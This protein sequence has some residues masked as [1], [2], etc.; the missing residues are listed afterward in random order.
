MK[1]VYAAIDLKSFYSSVECRERGLDPLTTNL[2]V[3]DQSRTEKTICLAVSPNLREYGIPGRARLFEVIARVKAINFDR[4]KNAPNGKFIGKSANKKVLMDHPE[5]ALDFIVAKPR[6]Q[7]YIDYSQK[8]FAS[9]LK[10]IAPEDIFA[11]SID[12]VFCDISGYLR[13]RNYAPRDFITMMIRDVHQ[14]TGITATAG[15]G[16]NLYLA[17]IAM[18][19]IAKHAKPNSFGVRIA[20]LDERSYREQLWAHTPITDFWRTGRGTARRLR[21]HQMYTMGDVARC[22]ITNEDLLF[23]LFGVNAELLIDHAWGIEPVGIHEI[24]SYRPRDH[25][26][27]NGQVLSRPY[28]HNEARIIVKEMVEDL[29]LKLTLQNLVTDQLVLD[30]NYDSSNKPSNDTKINHYG[31]VVPK[32]AHGTLRLNDPS[33]ELSKIRAGFTK[34]FDEI[35]NPTFTIRK[36]TL[37]IGNLVPENCQNAVPKQLNLF[38]AKKTVVKNSIH[39]KNLQAAILKIRKRFGKNAIFSG[40]NLEKGATGL[41]RRRQIGGHQE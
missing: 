17:K 13:L 35:A 7:K 8:V 19:I 11:Y 25:S 27:T 12:E 40:I 30:L 39:E 26:L 28:H 32:P 1:K 23:K 37:T 5:L 15:I 24:K 31:K 34:L 36:I 33:L 10:Y 4:Q 14:Q 38:D 41:D 20:E 16:T 3:A 2:V 6:M 18:D 9:Y 21:N 29:V 22:S